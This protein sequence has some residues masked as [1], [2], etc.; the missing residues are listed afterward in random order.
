MVIMRRHDYAAKPAL[1]EVRHVADRERCAW[2]DTQAWIDIAAD[3][4]YTHPQAHLRRLYQRF[5][6]HDG[7]EEYEELKKSQV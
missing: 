7:E 2:H 1:A 5:R 4:F 3:E 6:R